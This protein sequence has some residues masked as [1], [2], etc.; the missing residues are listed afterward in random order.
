M[1][2]PRTIFCPFSGPEWVE[3]WGSM[4]RVADGGENTGRRVAVN[5]AVPASVAPD[6][7]PRGSTRAFY[8]PDAIGRKVQVLPGRLSGPAAGSSGCSN[9]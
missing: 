2:V 1:S 6:V 5:D 7:G 8:R 4:D 9:T 3:S